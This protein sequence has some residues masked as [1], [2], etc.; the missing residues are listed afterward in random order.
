MLTTS[1]SIM[2]PSKLEI[3][4]LATDRSNWASY[5]DKL[6]IVLKMCRWQEHLTSD[7][8]TKQYNNHSD[9]NGLKPSMRWEDDDEAVKSILISSIP[10]EFFN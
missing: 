9:V 4:C 5:Q 3:T 8:V 2:D 10:E 1:F 6:N 7:L